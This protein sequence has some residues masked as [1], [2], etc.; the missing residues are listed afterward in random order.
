MTSFAANKDQEQLC[1]AFVDVAAKLNDRSLPRYGE[2]AV[3]SGVG[4][5]GT[6]LFQRSPGSH[7]GNTNP[8][9][10]PALVEDSRLCW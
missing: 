1:A 10:E 2:Q 5:P 3:W 4:H 6:P 7:A 8:L 9:S